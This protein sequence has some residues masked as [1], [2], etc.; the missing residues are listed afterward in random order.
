MGLISL[1]PMHI[2]QVSNEESTPMGISKSQTQ[3][4]TMLHRFWNLMSL[5]IWSYIVVYHFTSGLISYQQ[6]LNWLF[7]HYIALRSLLG[8]Y[9]FTLRMY[10]YSDA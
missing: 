7:G 4:A 1:W 5:T 6:S 9:K 2:I 8:E 10:F 3:H